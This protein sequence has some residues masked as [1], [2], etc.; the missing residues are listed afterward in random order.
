MA[1]A[2]MAG[3]G[4]GA[5]RSTGR[6]MDRAIGRSMRPLGRSGGL[7]RDRSRTDRPHIG[8]HFLGL[9]LVVAAAEA[10]GGEPLQQA[11]LALFRMIRVFLAPPGAQLGLGRT[12]Q[13]VDRRHAARPIARHAPGPAG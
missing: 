5:G 9:L 1:G 7:T 13:F 12:R 4:G 8:R 10:D 6:S 2:G 3:R 11:H